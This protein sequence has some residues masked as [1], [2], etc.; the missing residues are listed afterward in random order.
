MTQKI[1]F[2]GAGN[3]ASALIKGLI[4]NGH[5][6]NTI[7]AC[8]R[9]QKKLDRLRETLGIHVSQDSVSAVSQCESVVL[10]V[11]PQAIKGLCAEIRP[12]VHKQQPLIIS[13]AA[14]I[15]S[16]TLAYWLGEDTAI[17]RTMPNTPSSVNCGATGLFA[18]PQVSP[19]Q[20]KMAELL[21][22]SVGIYTWVDKE[23]H[24]DIVTALSGS[25][26]AYYFLLMEAMEQAATQLGL[27][28][29][30]ARLL[31]LQT[32]LGAAKMAMDSEKKPAE[33]RAEVTSPGGTTERAIKTFEQGHFF[34]LVSSAMSA[35][36]TRSSEIANQFG[37]KQ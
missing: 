27:P 22:G 25:G 3:M 10:A 26:P 34:T 33:L 2:I 37:G 14:G 13:V 1:A 24:L 4:K 8:D 15:S 30:T 19:Q 35:A 7:W 36:N 17:V 12:A 9:E 28:Q 29:N 18:R 32:A 11:K 20:K 21:M 31:T 23:Q 16:S 5:P 6:A